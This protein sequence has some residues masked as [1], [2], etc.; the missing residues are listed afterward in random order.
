M[1]LARGRTAR[2]AAAVLAVAALALTG[3]GG[4]DSFELQ[5]WHAP[6][7]NASVGPVLIRYAHVAEPK[8]EPWQP[9]DDVPA[10]V[11]LMNEGDETDRLVSASSPNAESVSVVNADG[12][13]LPHGVELPPDKLRQLEPTNDHLLLRDVRE[14]VRGGDFMKIT[15]NFEKAGSVTFNIQS[16]VPVYDSS[17]SPSG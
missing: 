6:G 15:L 3:C 1:V 16:Q 2:S 9:G 4:D 5:D 8:G 12:K 14:V 13:P 7:Q 10:Y 17:P 11:W